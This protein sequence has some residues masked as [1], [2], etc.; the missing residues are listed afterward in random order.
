[1]Q[2]IGADLYT[3]LEV[4]DTARLGNIVRSMPGYSF[5]VSNFGSHTNTSVNPA[6]ALAEAQ[7]IAFVYKADMFNNISTSALLSQ[8]INT[9][10]DVSS[11]NYNNWSS[12]RYPFMMNAD[13]TLNGIT[14]NIKFIGIHAKA[15]TSPTTTSYNRRKGGA[16]SLY[17]LLT[18]TYA[19]DNIIILGDFNDDLDQTITAGINPPTTSYIT[20]VNDSTNFPPVTLALSKTGKKSTVS[21]NDVIDHVIVSNEMRPFYMNATANILTDVTSLVSA[22]ASSTTDHYPVFTRYAF[23]PSILP[24]NLLTFTATKKSTV[25][26]IKLEDIK[27]NK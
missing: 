1:M 20:F 4:V 18:T 22:Y 25:S 9:A 17:K 11:T 27:R 6:S 14:K 5:V 2:N 8:G 16:D 7:K 23:D 24:V 15:N 13:V 10:Q 3:L 26:R 12:G 21:Y 19:N